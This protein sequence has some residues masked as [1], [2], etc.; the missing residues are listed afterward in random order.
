MSSDEDYGQNDSF[1]FLKITNPTNILGAPYSHLMR[2]K[3]K[4]GKDLLFVR[5]FLPDGKKIFWDANA[6][7]NDAQDTIKIDAQIKFEDQ[8][9]SDSIWKKFEIDLPPNS[10]DAKVLVEITTQES[11]GMTSTKKDTIYFEDADPYDETIIEGEQVINTPYLYLYHELVAEGKKFVPRCCMF[12]RGSLDKQDI[13]FDS[14]CNYYFQFQ[15]AD[16][17]QKPILDV[18]S[19]LLTPNFVEYFDPQE[20]GG[21]SIELIG[22]H[23]AALR[24]VKPKR[25]PTRKSKDSYTNA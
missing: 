6:R 25:K 16:D 13:S 17:P 14:E 8:T 23:N 10:D 24:A 21:F 9:A 20:N 15:I 12:L 5:T 7:L 1:M 4:K 22:N 2:P 18:N 3:T 11:S 19:S